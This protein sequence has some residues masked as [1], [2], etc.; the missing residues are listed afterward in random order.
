[1]KLGK[2]EFIMS[3]VIF[4]VFPSEN[5]IDMGLYQFGWEQC[6]P[7]HSFGPAARN[8]FLFHYVISGTGLLMAMNSSGESVQYSIKSGQGFMLFPQQICTYI[9]DSKIPWEYAWIEFDGLRVKQTIEMA[10]LNINN[11]VYKARYKDIAQTMKEEMLY[12]I[13]HKDASPFHL[14]GHLYIFIDALLRSSNSTQIT[15]GNTLRDFYIKEA[16]SYIEQNFQNEITI[17]DIAKFCGL[18]RSYFGKIFHENIGK[19]PQEF[20]ISYRMTKAAELLKL[21]DL[22]IADIGNAVGYPN[23]LHFSRAFKNVYGK[24]PRQWRYENAV[25]VK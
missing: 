2:G 13:N 25:P 14:I 10:G 22:P 4:S 8:H 7:S 9:A 20:L 16:I 18:N 1:M 12:I 17:E 24:S 23:Q 21:T 6:D 5:F 15:K 11:P 19:T 3:E